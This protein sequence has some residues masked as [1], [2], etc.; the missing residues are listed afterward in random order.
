MT[1]YGSVWGL[2]RVCDKPIEDGE[3]WLALNRYLVGAGHAHEMAEGRDHEDEYE[4]EQ[5]GGDDDLRAT[6]VPLHW[7]ICATMWIDG[8]IADINVKIPPDEEEPP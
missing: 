4:W 5:G 2:C 3:L 8:K 1:I 6:A 7:P